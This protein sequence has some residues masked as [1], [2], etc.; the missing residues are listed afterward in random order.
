ML[1]ACKVFA[2]K[3]ISPKI[4]VVK[5]MSDSDRTLRFVLRDING[6]RQSTAIELH[7]D[8]DKER[9][10]VN[11]IANTSGSLCLCILQGN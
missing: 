7:Y 1:W 6:Q 2:H 10:F 9:A 5:T 8:R 3:Q 4:P 11:T